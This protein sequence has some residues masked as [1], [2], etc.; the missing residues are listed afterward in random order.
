LRTLADEGH[1]GEVVYLHYATDENDVLYREEAEAIA[2]AHDNVRVV[3]GYTGGDTGCGGADLYG[4][5]DPEHLDRSAPWFR[6]AQTY[7]CGPTPLMDAVRVAF[8]QQGIGE[9]LHT[10]EFSP[11]TFDIDAEGATG[12][13]RF[14]RSGREID[15]TG[16]PLLEQAEDAGLRPE[17]GCRMGICFS[18]TKIKKVGCV[19]DVRS[20]QLSDDE[21]V[22]IQLCVSVPMGDVDIDC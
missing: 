13:V 10:E 14:S 5:F 19:R 18:C 9:R 21:G 3:F 17:H 16:H 20:G 1:S 2:A 22:E 11:P 4:L 12:T 15:N 7:L 6:S 8:E